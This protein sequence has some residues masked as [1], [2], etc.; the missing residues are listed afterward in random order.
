MGDF[1]KVDRKILKWEWWSDINTSRLFFY[2]LISAYWKDGNYKGRIIPRGSFP[3]SVSELA[4][5]TNLTENEIR[6][7][8]KHLKNT[9]EITSKST[10]KFT[11]FSVKNYDLYQSDNKQNCEQITSKNTNET[12]TNNEQLTNSILKEDKNIKNNNIRSNS[13]DLNDTE[14]PKT[15]KT[16]LSEEENQELLHNFEIIYNSYPRKVGKTAGFELYKQWLNGRDISGKR[17]KLTNRQM[18]LAIARYKKY[19]EDNE[20]KKQYIKQFDTFMRKPILDYIG[21]DEQ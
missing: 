19:I 17:I 14:K 16:K 18:W 6:T 11:V 15:R 9:G 8:L 21:D 13:D 7:A 4:K 20:T 5:E 3:S 10:N 12:Q 1:I 2:M